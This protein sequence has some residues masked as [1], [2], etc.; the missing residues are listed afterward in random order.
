MLS[1]PACLILPASWSNY[2]GAIQSCLDKKERLLRSSFD[3]LSKRNWRL[4]SRSSKLISQATR[5]YRHTIINYL[6]S[7]RNDQSFGRVAGSCL[8]AASDHDLLVRTCIE[9]SSSVYRHGCFRTYAAARLLRIWRRQGVDIQSSIFNFLA[10]CSHIPGLQ[11]RDV[12]RLL[13]ELVR[14][15]HLSVGKYLQRLIARGRLDSHRELHSVSKR[16]SAPSDSLLI[17]AEG[18]MRGLFALGAAFAGTAISYSQ[19]AKNAIEYPRIFFR[20]RKRHD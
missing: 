17:D 20:A 8:R 9:W 4:R 18:S 11:K 13:A 12:Y 6:D 2:E 3:G 19:S 1:A 10:A 16:N 14:S 7:L 5:T 15:R